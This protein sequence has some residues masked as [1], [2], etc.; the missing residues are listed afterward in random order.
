MS[1][2]YYVPPSLHCILL[3]LILLSPAPEMIVLLS[4]SSSQRKGYTDAVDWWSLGVTLFKLFTGTKPFEKQAPVPVNPD[5]DSLFPPPKKESEE[6]RILFQEVK[7]PDYIS[8]D[9]VELL[10]GFLNTKEEDRLGY[11]QYGIDDIKDHDF[12]EGINWDKLLMKHQVPPFLP[13]H[14]D[15]EEV[16]RHDTYTEML[17]SIGKEHWLEKKVNSKFQHFFDTWDYVSPDTL[18]IEFGIANEM[19]R[20]DKKFKVHQDKAEDTYEGMSS[21]NTSLHF[22][23]SIAPVREEKYEQKLFF[24]INEMEGGEEEEQCSTRQKL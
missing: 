10:R 13:D 9:G 5:D 4:Q 20:L 8:E 11:G 15:N 3:S 21:Y 22:F 19:D 18:R 2:L 6:Y 24:D 17:A 23:E 14:I 16:Q 1:E 7:Y 12:F